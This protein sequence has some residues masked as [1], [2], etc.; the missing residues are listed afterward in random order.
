VLQLHAVRS[1]AE[2]QPASVS[3]EGAG[4]VNADELT[5]TVGERMLS[6]LRRELAAGLRTR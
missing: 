4:A 2:Q 3:G 1:V 6:H 5:L